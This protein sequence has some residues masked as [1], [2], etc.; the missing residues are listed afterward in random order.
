MPQS[1]RPRSL[2]QSL[3]QYDSPDVDRLGVERPI[4]GDLYHRL[5]R[6]SWPAFFGL[7]ALCFLLVNLAF[8]WL[9]WL[10][11]GGLAYG[12]QDNLVTGY[13]RDFFFSV[14]TIATVGY[15]NVAPRSLYANG[16][17]VVEVACGIMMIA[18]MTGLLF[19][20][21]SRPRARILFSHVAVISPF[22]GIPTL[23]FRAA[24]QR[25]NFILEASVRVS[26]VRT[27]THDDKLIRRFHDLPLIRS[28]TPVFAL[29]WQV[30]HRIGEDSPLF[31]LSAADLAAQDVEI[32]VLMT[33]FDSSMAQTVRTRHAYGHEALI[34]D[35]EFVDILTERPQGRRLIDFG[36][37]HDIEPI[38][39]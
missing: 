19:A 8:G 27:E 17:V 2:A 30:M 36:R 20:R 23:K 9:Y 7:F 11:P 31:G 1:R 28:S 13:L 18:L 21:F 15:G 12:P 14:H 35:H 37:F 38:D 32:V 5:V 16:V 10:D 26:L 25:T 24:N 3:V 34:H 22:E 39:G 6:L 4:F 33:G 29:S